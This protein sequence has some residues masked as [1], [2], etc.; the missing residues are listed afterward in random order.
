M[1]GPPRAALFAPVFCGRL[2]SL[3]APPHG[4][5]NKVSQ[6]ALKSK[7]TA[8]GGCGEVERQDVAFGYLFISL[9]AENTKKVESMCAPLVCSLFFAWCFESKIN[10]IFAT[11]D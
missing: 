9:F 10:G 4:C 8:Y 11:P 2:I 5:P 6:Q 7:R 1:R 3:A